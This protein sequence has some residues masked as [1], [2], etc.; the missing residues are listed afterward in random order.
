MKE[1]KIN[2]FD[3]IIILI[4]LFQGSNHLKVFSSPFYKYIILVLFLFLIIKYVRDKRNIKNKLNVLTLILLTFIYFYSIIV[5]RD[6]RL[7]VPM[8]FYIIEI[9]SFKL[10][11][12]LFNSKEELFNRS[13]KIILISSTI[14]SILGFIQIIGYKLSIK[15]LYDFQWLGII[16]NYYGYLAE[17]RFYSIYDEPAH[18]CTILGSGIFA[19]YFFSKK[20]NKKYLIIL[21]LIL[22]FTFFTGSVV[23]Y[24]SL[25]IFLIYIVFYNKCTNKSKGR[26]TYSSKFITVFVIL[27]GLI[28]LVAFKSPLIMNGYNKIQNFFSNNSNSVYEQN[29]TTFALK[30]NYLI[31]KRKIEDGYIFGTGIF[32][33]EFYYYKYIDIVYK[34][35]YQKYLNYSDAAS[36]FVRILSEFGILSIL[37]YIFIIFYIIKNY[38]KKDYINMFYMMLFISQGMRLGDYTWLF[39]CLPIV[40]IFSKL[41]NNIKIEEGDLSEKNL[42]SNISKC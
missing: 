20:Y 8:V 14:I 24:A 33:H 23:T 28:L 7:V 38:K 27:I 42:Y 26:K 31:A 32:T 40:I 16:P 1:N 22:I 18:L 19:S 21:M 36:I 10:Y 11:I 13:L 6:S 34:S 2:I 30:S 25:L 39:N 41:N 29:E 3:F 17:G 12:G 35:H 37:V 9:F 4:I 15:L 5:S